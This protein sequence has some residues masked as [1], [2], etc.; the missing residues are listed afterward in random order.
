MIAEGRR[1]ARDV[2]QLA[3]SVAAMPTLSLVSAPILARALGPE[4]RGE[5]AAIV[6]LSVFLSS[7]GSFGLPD[8]ASY[9]VAKA[10]P[11]RQVLRA[12]AGPWLLSSGASVAIGFVIAPLMLHS[13]AEAIEIA[14]WVVCVV[15][16][17]LA[18]N[19]FRSSLV[20]ARLFGAIA[21]E[22]W[23]SA[24][25]RFGLITA[26]A[27]VGVLTVGSGVT[28]VV[29]TTLVAGVALLVLATR[30]QLL[31]RPDSDG[32]DLRARRIV[33]YSSRSWVGTLAFAING[34]LDQ[35]LMVPLASARSLGLYAVAVAVAELPS[36]V[37]LAVREALLPRAT[38]SQDPAQVGRAARRLTIVT[39]GIVVPIFVISPFVVPLVFGHEFDGSVALIQVLIAGSLIQSFG[40]AMAIG[41]MAFGRPGMRSLASAIT[42]LW[43][44]IVL[45]LLLPVLDAMGA[46][47]ASVTAYALNALLY[48]YFFARVSG[49]N[50]L[51]LVKF[52]REDFSSIAREMWGVCRRATS[53]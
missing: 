18:Q 41:L 39:A 53:R 3:M 16:L 22:R 50:A 20:G 30:A 25:A 4:G 28:I 1:G 7:L 51:S 6:A 48:T 47:I 40:T 15:P 12:S 36:F 10:H 42:T 9:Y 46:A 2:F 43:T 17:Y 31:M 14:K 38:E 49:A 11:V 32:G 33:G 26:C 34:R 21:L 5:M 23:I 29:G 35:I 13:N 52:N 19:V 24:L 44:A 27:A 8:A 45:V 37:A